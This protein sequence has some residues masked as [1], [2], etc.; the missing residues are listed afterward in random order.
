MYSRI[1]V[2]IDGSPTAQRGLEEAIALAGPLGAALH[3]LNVVDVRLLVN[4]VSAAVSPEQLLADW[5][6]AGDHLV[7]SAVK[8]ARDRGL[9]VD[10]SVRCD[11]GMRVFELIL[12]EASDSAAE[13]IVMGTHGRRG[14][15]RLALG[16]DAEMVLRES[17]VP[18]LLVR[19][20][21]EDDGDRA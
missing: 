4:E 19:G 1:L 15:R 11:P 14:L 5:R 7:T 12:Q 16:S 6:A 3:V 18:V 2:P 10:G 17:A 21:S 9:T 13:L 20:P 8:F